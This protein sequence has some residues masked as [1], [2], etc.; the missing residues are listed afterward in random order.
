MTAKRVLICKGSPREKG[1]SSTLAE[2]VALGAREA[3]A[4]VETISLH[5]LNI[6]PC[7][8]CDACQ[9]AGGGGHCNIDDDMEALYPKLTAADLIVISSPVY[10]FTL[11]A[12]AKLFIDRWYAL[13]KPEGSTLRGK[14]FAL[15]LAYGDTDPYT[16]GGIN[17]IHTFQDMVRYLRGDVVGIVYGSASN[18]GDVQKQPELM[19]RAYELGKKAGVAE[20]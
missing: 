10:W 8:G 2:Q 6:Q 14:D 19:E 7:T 1:N 18:L 13:E 3:G 12:Q 9:R 4:E 11:S 16:S 15:V 17:A 5:K 20:S